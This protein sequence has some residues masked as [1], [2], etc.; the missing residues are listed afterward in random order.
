MTPLTQSAS[1]ASLSPTE[2]I[3]SFDNTK[4]S[5]LF[6]PGRPSQIFNDGYNWGKPMGFLGSAKMAVKAT[7]VMEGAGVYMRNSTATLVGD[8][9]KG[10]AKFK[11]TDRFPMDTK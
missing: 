11:F 8:F 1:T 6:Q 5:S 9:Q 2:S 3:P 7:S 4:K 10:L